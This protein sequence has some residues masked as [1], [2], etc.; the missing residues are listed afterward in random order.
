MIGKALLNLDQ[1]TMHLDPNFADGCVA[2]QRER[3]P[4]QRAQGLDRRG[5][6]RRD[7]DEGSSPLSSRAPGQPDHGHLT[8]GDFRFGSMRWTRPATAHR[9]PN[10]SPTGS[11]WLIIAATIT[12]QR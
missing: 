5:G 4:D 8:E 7:R 2:G 1:A 3:D 6:S 11:R 9:A 12:G 10:A